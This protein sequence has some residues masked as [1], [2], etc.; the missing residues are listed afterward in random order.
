[1]TARLAAIALVLLAAP[2]PAA[3]QARWKE[4]GKTSS[5]NSVFVDRRSVERAGGIVTA[6][7][8][9]RF[10]TPVQTPK[11]AMTSS[12]TVAMLDCAKRRLAAKENV[13]Y[14]DERTNRVAE[15]TVNKLPGYGPALKGTLG[16]VALTYFCDGEGRKAK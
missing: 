7:V 5:G 6:V 3:A 9:V 8:R 14:I 15:R 4:I 1:M 12:R 16:D 13:Y 10:T 11:G 2:T